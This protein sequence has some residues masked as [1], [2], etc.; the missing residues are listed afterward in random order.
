MSGVALHKS[1]HTRRKNEDSDPPGAIEPWLLGFAELARLTTLSQRHLRRLDADRLIPGR[2]TVG[3]RVLF[4]AEVVR[5]WV[6]DG[7]SSA[8]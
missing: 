2:L 3:R 6:R 4:S 8:Q 5:T 1:T 7:M